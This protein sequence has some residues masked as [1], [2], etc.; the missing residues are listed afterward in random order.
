I[1]RINPNSY[2]PQRHRV[3]RD[4]SFQTL[5]STSSVSFSSPSSPQRSRAPEPQSEQQAYFTAEADCGCAATESRSI[6]RKA[7]KAAK[8][9]YLSE[10]GVLG[11]LAGEISE[12]E[13]FRV[14]GI[15]ASCKNSKP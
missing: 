10:L 13:M 7:A 3:R 5:P 14:S 6:S 11:A 12:S 2:S 9:Q 1:R 8:K 15:C 4:L